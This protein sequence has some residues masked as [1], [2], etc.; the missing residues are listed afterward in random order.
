[1]L[2]FQS[3]QEIP[4]ST[5]QLYTNS[6]TQFQQLLGLLKQWENFYNPIMA[7]AKE[8]PPREYKQLDIFKADIPGLEI[9]NKYQ[10]HL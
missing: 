2:S 7:I 3:K 9:Y 5:I 6:F 8:H 1:M 10:T 4:E